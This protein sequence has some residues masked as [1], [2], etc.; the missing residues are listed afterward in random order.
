MGFLDEITKIG[1]Q[2]LGGESQGG[3]M[4]QILGLIGSPEIGGLT[5]LAQTFKNKGLGDLISSWI[6]TGE[7][8]PV[9]P[10]QITDALGVD[11][12][13]AVAQRLGISGSD[14][15][16][17]LSE[18]LP[19]VIDKLTPNGTVPEESLLEEG[20]KILKENLSP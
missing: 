10:D 11:T 6:S 3:L 7:N 4:E 5:G 1:S 19:Q 20:L 16:V 13:Q 15:S 9:S 8:K 18:L 2:L 14:A 17:A 12:I